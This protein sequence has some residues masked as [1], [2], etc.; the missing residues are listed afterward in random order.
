LWTSVTVYN[1]A[2]AVSVSF[3][4]MDRPKWLTK[5]P[6]TVLNAG[7]EVKTE[8]TAADETVNQR[9]PIA[10]DKEEPS[11]RCSNQSK[12]RKVLRKNDSG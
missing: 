2:A 6:T 1:A 4:V 5:K 8:R 7:I 11:T 9:R 12:R 10:V 3:Y